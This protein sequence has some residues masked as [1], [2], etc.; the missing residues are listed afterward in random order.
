MIPLH[1]TIESR[2]Y[3]VVNVSIIAANVLVYWW[4]VGS[5]SELAQIIYTYG[6]VPARYSMP[7]IASYFSLPEQVFSFFSYMFLHGGFWHLLGNMWS[8]YIFGDNVE[9][10]LGSVKYLVFYL[11]CG[12]AS[13]LFHVAINYHSQVP[14]IGASGAIAGVMGAYFLLYPHSRILTLIPIFFLPYFIEIPAFV[15]LGFWFLFQFFSAAGT[16]AGGGGIAWWAHV[17]GFLFGIL[18]LKIMEAIPVAGMASWQG[19]GLARKRSRRLQVVSTTGQPDSLDVYGRITITPREARFGTRKLISVPRGLQK[20][21][22]RVTV[23]PGSRG[24]TILRL[25]GMGKEGADGSRGDL[26]LKIV[27]SEQEDAG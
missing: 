7:A 25:A 9:D 22:L 3:P 5:G 11:L 19:P 12:V 6:L 27:I 14:T 10:R 24:G 4:Q 21:L 16:V 20:S 2:N 23:P 15:F 1:D 13:G 17:G 18:F 26:Y 8:L